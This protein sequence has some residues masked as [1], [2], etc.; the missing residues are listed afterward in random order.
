MHASC[1]NF[2][3]AAGLCQAFKNNRIMSVYWIA[4]Q[5]SEHAEL[6]WVLTCHASMAQLRHLPHLK[7]SG[8][9]SQLLCLFTTCN[10]LPG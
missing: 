10:R 7:V 8:G 3:A 2:T 4:L 1:V 6:S 5:V 9:T